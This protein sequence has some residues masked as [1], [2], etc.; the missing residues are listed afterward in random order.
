MTEWDDAQR[1]PLAWN[2]SRTERT[3]SRVKRE[4]ETPP[5]LRRADAEALRRYAGVRSAHTYDA[6]W[7]HNA[8]FVFPLLAVLIAGVV[9]LATGSGEAGGATIFFLVVTGAML[10]VVFITWQRQTT[11]I[12]VH[13]DGITA[14]H[15]G[16]EQQTVPWHDLRGVRRVETMGNVR[17]YID[18]AD[19]E[20]IVIEGEIAD[21]ETLLAHA[22][23][24]LDAEV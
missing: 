3:G 22:E 12:V 13:E 4:V 11:A 20:H 2:S 21:R 10:P 19:E 16:V 8:T 15:A 5:P 24:R 14:L 6:S 17:W 9:W 23:E 1:F 7:Y 18:G